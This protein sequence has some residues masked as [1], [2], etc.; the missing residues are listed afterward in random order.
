MVYSTYLGGSGYDRGSGI[1]VDSAGN[2]YVTGGTSSTDFPVTPGAFQTTCGNPSSCGNA[3]VAKLNP[4]GSTLVYSTYL[5]GSGR[6]AGS[7][8]TVDSTGN[9]YVTGY[10]ASTD[11]PVT[12]G[13]FQTIC[14]GTCN[15]NAFVT[16]LNPTGSALVYSTYLGDRGGGSGIAVDGADNAYVTGQTQS[17]DFPVTPG[18]FQTTCTLS[19]NGDCNVAFVTKINPTG[20]A[21]V[22]STY[23]GGSNIDS[24]FGIAVDSAGNAYVTGNT[25]SSDFPTTPGAFQTNYGGNRDAF[26]T[27]INPT[28][29]ALVYSTYLGGSGED[30]GFGIAVDSAGNAY[31]TGYTGSNN[32]P[33]TPNAIRKTFKQTSNPSCRCVFVSGLIPKGSALVYSTYLGGCGDYGYG[34]AVD[35]V[36]NAYVTGSTVAEG[37]P[38]KNPLQPADGGADDTFV[39]KIQMLGVTTTTLTSSPYPSIYGETVTFTAV[40]TSIVGAPPDGETVSFITGKTV[41]GTGTLSGGSATFTTSTLKAGTTS[42][43]AVYGGDSNFPGSKSKAVKQVVSK[44]TTTTALASSLNPSNSGQWVTFTANVTP[45]FSGTVAGTVTFHDG[46]AK[47][48]TASLSEGV[49]EFTTSKLTSGAHTITATYNGSASFDGSSASLAQT[50]N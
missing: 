23:L 35:S 36:G 9:A 28:G 20:S 31:V 19:G 18:A 2:A 43:T 26:V 40:V 30:L 42:V 29:S 7:G 48:T 22:Y 4:T 21:L 25:Y 38:T 41:R 49:A 1:A 32:F 16:K 10:T 8:I 34:I 50:V 27:K 17:T 5:G 3:F 47:L 13:A 6:S 39:T 14:G 11:F 33:T 45:Q 37:I 46:A 15:G 44:A 12:P 24:G